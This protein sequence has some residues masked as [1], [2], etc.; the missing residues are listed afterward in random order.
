MATARKFAKMYTT[1][2]ETRVCVDDLSPEAR[3]TYSFLRVQKDVNMAGI[4]AIRVARWAKGTGYNRDTLIR[5]INELQA[6][7]LVTVDPEFEELLLCEFIESDEVFRVPNSMKNA[8]ECVASA[9]S[10][11]IKTVLY[12]EMK[13]LVTRYPELAVNET[14]AKTIYKLIG[15]LEGFAYPSA[16]PLEPLSMGSA[17]DVE[18]LAMGIEVP[19]ARDLDPLAELWQT[20]TVPG[21]AMGSTGVPSLEDLKPKT[22]NQD[23]DRKAS[24]PAGSDPAP[25]GD[26]DPD[27][28]PDVQAL[29]EQLRGWI[30]KN[31]TGRPRI[32]RTWRRDMRLLLDVDG[33]TPQQVSVAIDWCQSNAFWYSNILSPAS[34]REKYP[35][36]RAA[37]E[38]E[39]ADN[40]R[41]RAGQRAQVTTPSTAEEMVL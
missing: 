20:G 16:T 18:A 35:K 8:Y 38:R 41:G 29:C 11:L 34:L 5:A 13:G 31:D 27:A 19:P 12:R 25:S 36:L 4:I 33:R 7:G 39:K 3:W 1:W 14:T 28:R 37:A 2:M 10:P 17:G 6:A 22:V 30:L 21:E 26:D 24:E 40:G 15:H 23:K 9:M 32:G